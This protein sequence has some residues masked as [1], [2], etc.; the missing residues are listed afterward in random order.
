MA[1]NLLPEIKAEEERHLAT[2][3]FLE[4]VSFGALALTTAVV[5]ATFFYWAILGNELTLLNRKITETATQV[6]ELSDVESLLRGLKLKL[7][8]LGKILATE[9]AHASILEDVA[10][11]AGP[12]ITL[13]D[14][15][16]KEGGEVILAGKTSAPAELGRLVSFF[17]Q[18][19]VFLGGRKI[20][21]A[22]L[23]QASKDPAGF[24]KFSLKLNLEKAVSP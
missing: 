6:N 4:L 24:Y 2:K 9:P 21:K 1:I 10:R 3:R 14:V 18:E 23:A 7:T 17:A 15:V 22:T 11:L 16:L 13:T 8:S 12:A 5:V 20:K 19:E